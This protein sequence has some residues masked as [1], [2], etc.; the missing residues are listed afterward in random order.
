LRNPKPLRIGN[1][2][3]RDLQLGVGVGAV[4]HGAF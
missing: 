2:C 1:R 4:D 3:D